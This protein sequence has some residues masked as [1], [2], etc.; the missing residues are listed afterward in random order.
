MKRIACV[1]LLAGWFFN[2]NATDA[3]VL[4]MG[5]NDNFFMDDMS[6]FRNPANINYYPNMLLGSL[7][8][9][10]PGKS[11]TGEFAALQRTNTDPQ[12][13]FG[14]T[15]LSYSLNQ[16]SESGNQY[17]LLSLGLVLNRWDSYLNYFDPTS[18]VFG[19]AYG[20]GRIRSVIS[21]VGKI[22]VMLGYAMPNGAMIGVGTYLAFQQQTVPEGSQKVNME[23]DLYK[24]DIGINWPLAKSMNLEASLGIASAT[25]RRG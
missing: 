17:P 15:I 2:S 6:I 3:R 24:G 21:P 7:G 12:R 19:A 23:S 22:D 11:D 13:P 25:K 20:A 14:G 5:G 4:S 1:V 8:I 10:E 16:S 9:Y 18:D